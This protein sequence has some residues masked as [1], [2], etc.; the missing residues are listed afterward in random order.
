MIITQFAPVID[1]QFIYGL[2]PELDD[3]WHSK[4]FI[5]L[6]LF[7]EL[8]HAIEEIFRAIIS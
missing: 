4:G 3:Q 1:K 6:V 5:F 8:D 2:K 7:I